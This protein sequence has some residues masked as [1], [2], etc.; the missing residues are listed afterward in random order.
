MDKDWKIRKDNINSLSP[1]NPEVKF[2]Q[3]IRTDNNKIKYIRTTIHED[4]DDNGNL[5]NG[6]SF[7]QDITEE[8]TYQNKLKTTLKI[9]F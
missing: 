3:R 6:I 4:Y 9:I 1:E 8:V 5:I 7:N 2:I